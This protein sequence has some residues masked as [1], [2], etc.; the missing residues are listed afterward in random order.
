[1]PTPPGVAAKR[2]FEM[3]G[4]E[5]YDIPTIQGYLP[6][7]KNHTSTFSVDVDSASYA[8]VRRT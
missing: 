7:A 2:G 4:G 6:A 5:R 8:N 1:M 3:V